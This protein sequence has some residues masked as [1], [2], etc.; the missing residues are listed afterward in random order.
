[1]YKVIRVCEFVKEILKSLIIQI[2]AMS[3]VL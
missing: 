3:T 2:K 1:M